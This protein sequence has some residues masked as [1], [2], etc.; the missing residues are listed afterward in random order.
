MS[1]SPRKLAIGKTWPQ[2]LSTKQHLKKMKATLKKKISMATTHKRMLK[3]YL[4]IH[5]FGSS[6]CSVLKFTLRGLYFP[7]FKQMNF[8]FFFAKNILELLY[9]NSG[10]KQC[11]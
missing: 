11:H 7:L 8:F 6:M 3:H 1:E 10:F 5:S 4:Y 9:P 2:R